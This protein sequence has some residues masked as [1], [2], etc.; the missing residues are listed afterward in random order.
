MQDII[1]LTI[2]FTA[3]AYAVWATIKTIR[4]K[5]TGCCGDGCSCSAKS[6]IKKAILKKQL[7]I[8]AEKLSVIK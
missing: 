5:S 8:K 6:D 4:V 1:V 7:T 2:V 3:A